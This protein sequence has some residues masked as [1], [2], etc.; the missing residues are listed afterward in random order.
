MNRQQT[1][2]DLRIYTESGCTVVIYRPAADTPLRGTTATRAAS[3]RSGYAHC[4]PEF[5]I[6]PSCSP[7]ATWGFR[8]LQIV[9]DPNMPRSTKRLVPGFIHT[10]SLGDRNRGPQELSIITISTYPALRPE[11]ERHNLGLRRRNR[12]WGGASRSCHDD[13]GTGCED[14]EI[15]GYSHRCV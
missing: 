5:R 4:L 3:T 15:S 6:S 8:H 7:S 12:R 1:T 9:L 13:R 11:L 14:D 2:Y 10:H